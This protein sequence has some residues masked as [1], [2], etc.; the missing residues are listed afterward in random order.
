MA[1]SAGRRSCSSACWSRTLVSSS[2]AGGASDARREGASALVHV[3]GEVMNNAALLVVFQTDARWAAMRTHGYQPT[4]RRITLTKVDASCLRALEIDGQPAARRYAELVGVDV[5]Q[6]GWDQPHG[7]GVWPTAIAV[8]REYV[9]RAPWRVL[10]DGSV[11]FANLVE[12]GMELEIMRAGDLA[13]AN[14]K[15][16][17]EE[18]PAR[19]G[20]PTAALFFTCA[21]RRWFSDACGLTGE[22]SQSFAA[23]PRAVGMESFFEIY[24][25]FNLNTTLSALVFGR[26]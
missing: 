5:D 4:G 17:A 20:P 10:D 9:M 3:D 22:V 25:G 13:G 15:F 23:A 2:S 11:L 7:F 14:R 6:L 8:G 16:L 1:T 19:V 18:M 21:G 24:C 26:S 12:E